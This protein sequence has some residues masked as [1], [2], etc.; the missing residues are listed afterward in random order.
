VTP[1]DHLDSAADA[2]H[3]ARGH[4]ESARDGLEDL[5]AH[6][7]AEL[8]ADAAEISRRLENLRRF[9]SVRAK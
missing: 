6:A 8:V 2:L 9:T 5:E 7:A 3:V 1:G 4:L